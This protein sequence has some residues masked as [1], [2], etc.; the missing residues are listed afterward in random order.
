MFIFPRQDCLLLPIMHSTAEELAVYIYG[1]ILSKLDA[2][3]LTKR[4]VTT[5]EITVSEASGQDATFRCAIPGLLER[6]IDFDVARFI[7][8]NQ[9]PAMPCATET[10]A[11]EPMKVRV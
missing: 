1:K 8:E 4:G 9:I 10:I 5:M 7:S 2:N 3:Y 11:A 6:E